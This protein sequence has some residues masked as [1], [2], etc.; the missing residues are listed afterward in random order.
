MSLQW[1]V[2][3]VLGPAITGLMLGANL[4]TAWI[5][6]MFLGCFLSIPIFLAMKSIAA[7]GL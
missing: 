5:I 3:G 6:T 7:K 2:S 1:S 4:G